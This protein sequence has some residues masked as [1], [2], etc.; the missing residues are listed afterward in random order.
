MQAKRQRKHRSTKMVQKCLY[1]PE[2]LMLEVDA[3][4]QARG[5]S[6]NVA[7]EELLALALKG[8]DGVPA[9]KAMVLQAFK[10]AGFSRFE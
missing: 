4:A 2:E 7:F 10:A 9:S 8:F 5:V 1:L 6:R 3:Y